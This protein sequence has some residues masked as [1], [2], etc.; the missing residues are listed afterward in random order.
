MLC[1]PIYTPALHKYV[2]GHKMAFPVM[3]APSAMHGLAHPD[4]EMATARA[5]ANAGIPMVGEHLVHAA[6]ACI[7][8]LYVGVW[9]Q[10]M[11]TALLSSGECS[12][13]TWL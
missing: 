7:G 11:S 1:T 8:V 3:V 10:G 4:K 2:A 9:Q 12:C 6:H 5:A 13:S